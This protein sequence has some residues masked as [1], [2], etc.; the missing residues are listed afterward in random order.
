MFDYNHFMH[1]FLWQN[2]F[3]LRSLC[4]TLMRFNC[5]IHAP[6]IDS[7]L[8]ACLIR[9]SFV[10]TRLVVDNKFRHDSIF[11]RNACPTQ[12]WSTGASRPLVDL[13]PIGC[14]IV[15]VCCWFF[16]FLLISICMSCLCRCNV[17]IKRQR[18]ANVQ[19]VKAYNICQFSLE[20]PYHLPV[21]SKCRIVWSLCADTQPPKVRCVYGAR[22][23]P[24][25][26]HKNMHACN[27]PCCPRQVT[28]VRSLACTK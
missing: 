23:F 24:I 9:F 17:A 28:A 26:T 25:H 6:F 27:T 14:I 8:Y 7:L 15:A 5:S 11:T 2:S 13:L 1:N 19:R 16:W 20:F 21:R 4:F 3:L 22:V 10:A 12:R 18:V